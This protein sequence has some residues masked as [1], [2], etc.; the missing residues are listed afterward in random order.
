MPVV[1]S[2]MVGPALSDSTQP[3]RK[4]VR[5]V[6][7]ALPDFFDDA[8]ASEVLGLSVD[9]LVGARSFIM[10]SMYDFDLDSEDGVNRLLELLPILDPEIVKTVVQEI[11]P[12]YPVDSTTYDNTL[13]RAK[14]RGYLLDYLNG[15]GT[16]P[17]EIDSGDEH[18]P[19]G[20][21]EFPT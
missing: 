8:A 9:D 13:S 5:K 16:E 14:V 12:G 7:I 21:A 3:L 18:E 11:W 1:H 19:D 4:S 15:H 17:A 6:I 2:D 10:K 20:G